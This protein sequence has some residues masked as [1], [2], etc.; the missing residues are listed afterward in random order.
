MQKL[1]MRYDA[2]N[3]DDIDGRITHY[4]IGDADIATAC[5]SRIWQSEITHRLFVPN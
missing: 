3:H 2:G 1:N 4:L 5:V